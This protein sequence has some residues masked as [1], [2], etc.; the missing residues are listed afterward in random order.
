VLVE[1]L[2]KSE[3]L[4]LGGEKKEITVLFSDIR[5]FTSM[6][7]KME[8]EQIVALLNEYLSEMNESIFAY[9]GTLDKFVGDAVM[10]LFNTPAP[11]KDHALYAVKT[12]F[13]MKRRLAI[14]NEKWAKEGRPQLKIGL[15][16]NT[17]YAVAGNMGSLKRMEYTVIGDTVNLAARL[18]SATKALGAEILISENTY[19]KVRG[20]VKARKIENVSVKGKEESL[21]V[22]DV[23]ELI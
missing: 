13:D 22:Y 20:F 4:K 16:I 3:E 21:T 14:L 7:E 6:S 19:D 1:E 23:T 12:A 5:G 9:K 18:E 10:A 2:L 17:G 11:L 8:P 15:G